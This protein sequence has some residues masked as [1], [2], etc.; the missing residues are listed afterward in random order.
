[1][2][3]RSKDSKLQDLHEDAVT[4]FSR[5]QSALRDERLQCLQDRRFYSIAGAQWEGPLGLQFENKPK[6]EV[7]KIHLA[8]LRIFGEYRNNRISVAFVSKDGSTD[9]ALADTCAA[10]YRSDEQDS[11]AEEAYDNAFEEAVGGGFG[12]WRLRACYEDEDGGEDGVEGDDNDRRQRIR[13]EPIFDA[14]SSVFFDL[15]AKRQDKSDA[16]ACFVITSLTHAEYKRQYDD[17]PATWPKIVHQREFD[18]LTPDVVYLAEY[19]RKEDVRD[20]LHT[21]RGLDGEEET[22]TGSELDASDEEDSGG[23]VGNTLRGTLYATGFKETVQK[24]IKRQRVHKYLMNGARIIEDLGRIAG[25]E[26][27]IVPVYGKRWFI[28]NVERCM[29]HV[30]VAKDSQRIKNMQISKL[31]E[32]S[33]LSTVEKPIFTPEQIAGHQ[34][35]WSEDNIK[36]YPYMLL[37]PVMDAAGQQ[38]LSGPIGSTR[39]PAV[40]QALAA[41]LQLA[42]QDMEEILGNPQQ[43]EKMVSHVA[44]KTVEAIQQRVDSNSFIY[45]SNMAKAIRR[46]GQVWLSMARELYTDSDRKMKG[47]DERGGLSQ[48]ELQKP[49]LD[50][51]GRL[52]RDNDM[53]RAVFD[54]AVDIGPSSVSKREA[55]V[56]TITNLMAVTQDQ[57]TQAVLSNVAL[58]NMEGEGIEDVRAWSR[59]KLVKA[60]VLK[61]TPDETKE[62][63]EEA[64]NA[65][66][67]PNDAYLKA[68]ADE[69]QAKAQQ[70]SADVE[71]IAARVAK[72]KADTIET[73][74]GVDLNRK[75][76][77]VDAVES[78]HG[79]LTKPLPGQPS[80]LGSES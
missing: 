19:Y 4:E 29:G 28:D 80:G 43:A 66:P 65:Q 52:I 41:L 74:A 77:A 72:T 76:A 15:D 47:V 68:A 40:P 59:R 49:A 48:I 45:V 5:I 3:R 36:N 67:T 51:D 58:M 8:L 14:D 32:I 70:A 54:V 11:S 71:L 75:K 60:G 16:R 57:E 21:F 38:A 33:A 24:S 69:L 9:T 63:A 56:R 20:T 64:K 44:G 73:L 37:N 30:R 53:S 6:L 46:C 26:I 42:G 50:V 7:N 10:L 18:W 1:M 22:H 25:R 79:M 61:P 23:G 34:T 12:A 2:G 13:I 17:D 31:A 78:L 55:A 62:L 27:P 39:A 35:M